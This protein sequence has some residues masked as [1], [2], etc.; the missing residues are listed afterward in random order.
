MPFARTQTTV[1]TGYAWAVTAAPRGFARDR[2][3]QPNGCRARLAIGGSDCD[4][5]AKAEEDVDLGPASPDIVAVEL[6]KGSGCC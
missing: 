1:A 4:V 3:R 6:A 5:A 2:R